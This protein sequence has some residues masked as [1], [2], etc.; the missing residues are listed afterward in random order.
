MQIMIQEVL[1]S[2][3][4]SEL[5]IL[6][7]LT[8]LSFES[9]VISSESI[10]VDFTSTSFILRAKEIEYFDLEYQTKNIDK[11]ILLINA[12]KH[13]YYRDVYVFVNRFKNMTS[14]RDKSAIKQIITTCFRDFALM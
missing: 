10:F 11:Q 9:I 4:S 3:S 6:F 14:L 5:T 13:V 7:E 1:N 2:A 12:D 8:I